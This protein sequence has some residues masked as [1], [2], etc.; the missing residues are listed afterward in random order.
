M[1]ALGAAVGR[2]F[3]LAPMGRFGPAA[4]VFMLVLGTFFLLYRL[5]PSRKVPTRAAA[6]GALISFLVWVYAMALIVLFGGH[7]AAAFERWRHA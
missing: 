7:L 3:G 2:P 5:A 6:P 4:L 1:S